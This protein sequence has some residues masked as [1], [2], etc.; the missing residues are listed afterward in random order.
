MSLMGIYRLIA[1]NQ[2]IAKYLNSQ[3]RQIP[4]NKEERQRV[5]NKSHR[6]RKNARLVRLTRVRMSVERVLRRRIALS[7]RQSVRM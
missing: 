6:V 2:D 3:T 5:E 1:D 4:R 7:V